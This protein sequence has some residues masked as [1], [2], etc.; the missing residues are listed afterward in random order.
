LEK[1]QR[2]L[3]Q[4]VRKSK[5]MDEVQALRLFYE[6]CKAVGYLHERKL[7]HRDI[8]PENIL[9][10]EKGEIK[11][12]DFGFCAPYGMGE[13]RQTLCGT[14]EYLC[15]EIILGQQQNEKVDIWCLGVLLF[16]MLHKRIPFNGQSIPQLMASIKEMKVC[17][18]SH[19]S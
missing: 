4:V 1:Q 13:E 12:C 16:E 14:K 19:I 7:V 10:G 9:I 15:P 11:L 17:F 3:F 18:A 8:K 2:N 6:V 5:A